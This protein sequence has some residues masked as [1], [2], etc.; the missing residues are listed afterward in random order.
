M[1]ISSPF[2]KQNSTNKTKISEQNI[3][4]EQFILCTK[5]S[6]RVEI[7]CFTFWCFLYIL[8]FSLKKTNGLEIVLITSFTIV[9]TAGQVN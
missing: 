9:L 2:F 1:T 7:V 6:K 5:T 3:T 4:G 8:N